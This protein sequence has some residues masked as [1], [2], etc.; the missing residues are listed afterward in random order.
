M[1]REKSIAILPWEHGSLPDVV[2]AEVE[3]ADPLHSDASSGMRR[4]TEAERIDV[5]ANRVKGWKRKGKIESMQL[6]TYSS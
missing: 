4:T 5:A 6:K 1:N 3:H 2:E